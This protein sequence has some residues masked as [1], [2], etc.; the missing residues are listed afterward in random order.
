MIL[1]YLRLKSL[2]IYDIIY[3]FFKN[4]KIIYENLSVI[5]NFL[6]KELSAIFECLSGMNVINE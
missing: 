5:S 2:S 6:T 1:I 3:K 4:K